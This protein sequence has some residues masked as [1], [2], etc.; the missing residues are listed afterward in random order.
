MTSQR[1]ATV[2]V[3]K[4]AQAPQQSSDGG[5]VLRI[6]G[7]RA[8]GRAGAAS[9]R[10]SP[11]PAGAPR[12][13][14]PSARTQARE[15]PWLGWARALCAGPWG[16]NTRLRGAWPH[17]WPVCGHPGCVYARWGSSFGEP[18]SQQ[19]MS[20]DQQWAAALHM[21][22]PPISCCACG[23]PPHS[24]HPMKGAKRAAMK[25]AHA[26]GICRG[27]PQAHVRG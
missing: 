5:D 25:E 15:H 16:A 6:L 11:R 13:S 23:P 2:G 1:M 3:H 7:G 27:R 14:A 4:S 24:A 10:R 18:G 12:K 17:P 21:L 8:R 9:S 19:A 22:A 26:Y 20:R